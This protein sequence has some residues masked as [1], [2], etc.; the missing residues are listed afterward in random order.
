MNMGRKISVN[1]HNVLFK[2]GFKLTTA[3]SKVRTFEKG[4]IVVKFGETAK[5][6]AL[7]KLSVSTVNGMVMVEEKFNL[8]DY[9][10]FNIEKYN[11]FVTALNSA[12]KKYKNL[13]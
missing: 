11:E 10:Q 13:A 8:G 6:N 12:M 3:T 7:L 2:V 1:I 9:N 4:R 5:G